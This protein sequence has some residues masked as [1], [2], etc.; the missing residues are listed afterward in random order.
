MLESS[1][2]RSTNGVLTTPTPRVW[3]A[4]QSIVSGGK[5]RSFESESDN[6]TVQSGAM[7]QLSAW[8]GAFTNNAEVPMETGVYIEIPDVFVCI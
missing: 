8:P 5:S 6:T 1:I 2:Y 7:G 3:L 4:N